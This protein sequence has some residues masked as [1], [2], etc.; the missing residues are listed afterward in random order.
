MPGVEWAPPVISAIAAAV[1][2]YAAWRA[3]AADR[4]RQEGRRIVGKAIDDGNLLLAWMREHG[5]RGPEADRRYEAWHEQMYAAVKS[6]DE[7]QLGDLNVE[8][9]GPASRTQALVV[10]IERLREILHRL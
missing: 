4:R 10:Y 5:K 7:A 1:S 8:I 6:A 9:P 3:T 2:I